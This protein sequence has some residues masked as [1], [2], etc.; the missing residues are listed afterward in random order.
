MARKKKLGAA[1][2]GAGWVAGE[3]IRAYLNNP[4]VELKC[5]HSRFQWELDQKKER[6]GLTCDLWVN[7]LDELLAREDIDIVSLCTINFLHAEQ[8]IA[9]AEAGKHILIEKPI[10]ITLEELKAIKADVKKAGGF[11][12][13]GHVQRW[14]PLSQTIKNRVDKGDSG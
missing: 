6:F 2:I 13:S 14:N 5:V 8:A 4:H 1:V 9:A 11:A 7:R 12:N 10:C 3:H